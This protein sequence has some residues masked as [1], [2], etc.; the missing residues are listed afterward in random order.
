MSYVHLSITELIFIE[1][2][3]N[4]NMSSRTIAKHLNRSHSCINR[5]LQK[6][7]Q[8][9]LPIEIHLNYKQNKKKCGR[10]PIVLPQKER[11]YIS[12]KVSE[13]WTPD[14]IIGRNEKPISCSM[15]TLYRMFDKGIFDKKSLPLQGKRK[16]N[17][18]QE[19]RGK[20]GFK[21]SIDDRVAEY[22]E[23]T[24]E[25]GHLEGDT[26][27]GKDHKSSIITLVERKSKF[28]FAIQP[29]DK[30]AR[31]IEESV[32][33][34]LATLPKNFFSTIIFDC[35]KEFSNWKNISNKSDIDIYFADPGTPSQRGLNENSN[36]LL[37]R[38]GLK[39]GMDINL[40]NQEFIDTVSSRRNSIPRKSLKY[41]TPTECFNEYM[42]RHCI[43]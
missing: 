30:K 13:G 12:G 7:K 6:I 19:K 25:F 21:R 39:K 1:E 27:V 20:Q 14:V 29:N 18:H 5:V 8:G 22:P 36:G 24:D 4:Q 11:E 9:L 43:A 15:R 16:P 33:Q 34:L 2:Y 38:D 10:K 40:I 41:R 32:N 31:D 28:I 42:S 23:F 17:G 3:F 37:R 26:I 35:G